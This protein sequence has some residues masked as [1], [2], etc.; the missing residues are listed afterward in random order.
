MEIAAGV[1][2][3]HLVRVRAYAILEPELTLVDAGL[4]GSRARIER[5]L[6]RQGRALAELRRIVCTHGH[7]DHAGACASWRPPTSRS[8]CTG[9]TSSASSWGFGRRSAAP[10]AAGSWRP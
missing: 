10:R 1:H 4:A 7:P 2:A 9:P 3:I 5:A 8:A 6:A